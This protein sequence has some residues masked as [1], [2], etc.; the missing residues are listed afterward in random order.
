MNGLSSE[1]SEAFARR[2]ARVFE[3]LAADGALILAAAPELRVGYDTELRYAVDADLYYLTGYT[4]AE[5][6]LVL[7][8]SFEDGPYTMFVRPRDVEREIWTG[9]RGGP[10][11]AIER[12]GADAAHP[13]VELTERLPKMLAGVNR[14][15]ARLDGGRPDVEAL[16]LAAVRRARRARPRRGVGPNALIEPGAILDEMRLR[17][18][19]TELSELR[20][21]ADI[22][23]A[24][25]ADAVA[26][27]APGAGEWRIEAA[28]E[29]GFR[30]RGADG[31]AFPSIVASGANA[32]VLHYVENRRVMNAGELVLL[33]A[34]A[35]RGMYCADISR[36]Y[37]VSGPLAAEQAAL[38]AGVQA[39]RD[40]GIAAV[41]AGASIDDPHVAALSVLL[42]T[43]RELGFLDGTI[44]DLQGREEEWKPFFPHRTSHWLGLDV[45]DVGDYVVNGE[46]RLLEP[47][48]VLTI[49]PGLYI[50][51]SIER[52][53]ASLRG[54]GVRIEDDVLVTEHGPD[55]LTAL[56]PA[57]PDPSDAAGARS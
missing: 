34:G 45:H 14:V 7:C 22:S 53:P 35:R 56:L 17:K 26:C 25:F 39:A 27:I 8:P 29:A 11:A 57:G 31:A 18:D 23:V 30:S 6:V 42:E 41:R 54:A 38:H 21:A 12:F 28:L 44:H 24:A 9:P 43:L 5:A 55:V 33:D 50:P 2:R 20:R 36:T 51:A 16:V 49:E 15:F 13:I 1:R 19:G 37:A 46:P 4:E 40:A 10:A 48:M 32:A 47:G 3:T 52:G